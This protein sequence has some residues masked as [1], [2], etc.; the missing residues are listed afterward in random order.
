MDGLVGA[1]IHRVERSG[2]ERWRWTAGPVP[3]YVPL[4]GDDEEVTIDGEP[5]P[6]G[7]AC[8][9]INSAGMYLRTDGYAG[10]IGIGTPDDGRFDAPADRFGLSFAA[11]VFR[12][13]TWDRLGPLAGPY[14][15][16]YEDVDWC[17][18]A[19]LAGLRLRYEPGS[20]VAHRWSATS[21]GVTGPGVRVLAE[22]NR[23]LTIVRNAP[24]AVAVD[25]L[26]RRWS[27]GSDFG[28]RS[29]AARRMPWAG[30]TRFENRWR[31]GRQAPDAVWE[32]WAGR[33][34]DWDRSPAF[35]R[36]GE[37]R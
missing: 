3:F 37:A 7:P 2:A 24:R 30:A 13:S 27:G 22:S 19:H 29:R 34:G 31:G 14:F 23:T 20:T 17:W 33:N 32:E 26:R 1:G 10:D 9:L 8:A 11:V 16:Y 18:R 21:G 4:D 5:A 35:S 36:S 12:R 15:A 25:H 6:P 28:V